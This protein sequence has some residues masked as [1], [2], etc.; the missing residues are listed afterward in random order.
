MI[1]MTEISGISSH[2]TQQANQT[3]QFLQDSYPT[4]SHCIST[5]L[6]SNPDRESFLLKGHP[7]FKISI[8]IRRRGR[9]NK[10]QS[11]IIIIITTIILILIEGKEEV[12]EK[13]EE[14]KEIR[15]SIAANN[16]AANSQRRHTY[17]V[18]RPPYLHPP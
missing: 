8:P 16:P 17:Q 4:A 3:L 6:Y 2:L 10:Y 5:N 12:E 13:I 1:E 15:L 9:C 7:Y 18:Y 11:G 14:K